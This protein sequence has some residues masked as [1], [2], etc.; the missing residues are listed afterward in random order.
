MLG[1]ISDWVRNQLTAEFDALIQILRGL[2]SM[3]ITMYIAVVIIAISTVAAFIVG[4]MY[5]IL[6]GV[7]AALSLALKRE[8]S[9]VGVFIVGG[10]AAAALGLALAT[11]NAALRGEYVLSLSVAAVCVCI[12]LAVRRHARPAAII[13]TGYG[14]IRQKAVLR[15]IVQRRF[16]LKHSGNLMTRSST[17]SR[18]TGH[19]RLQPLHAGAETY[20]QICLGEAEECTCSPH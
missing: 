4:D 7:L 3:S 5:L 20:G 19:D 9:M 12:V 14:T 16:A 6:V 13:H 18:N 15:V 17:T 1:A 2:G 10:L 8:P 11:A